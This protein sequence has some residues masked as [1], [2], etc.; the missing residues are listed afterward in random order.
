MNKL[1]LFILLV[2]ANL[3]AA[4]PSPATTPFIHEAFVQNYSE[5]IPLELIAATPPGARDEKPPLSKNPLL[6]WI[7]GYWAWNR[8]KKDFVW[9]CGTWRLPPPDRVWLKGYWTEVDNGWVWVRGAW[10]PDQAKTQTNWVYSK[11]LPPSAQNEDTGQNP[12]ADSFWANGYW[13]FSTATG[14]Y[15][16]LSGSWQKFNP[17]WVYENAHW[18][19]RP[20]G[21]LFVP[22]FWDWNLEFRGIAYDCNNAL[23]IG[24]SEIV[25]ACTPSYPDYITLCNHSWHFHPQYWE[26]CGCVPVWWSWND[27]WSCPWQSHWWL[28]WWYSHPGYPYPPFIDAAVIN[29]IPPPPSTLIN[30][31]GGF[32]PPIYILP[33]GVPTSDQWLDAIEKALGGNSRGPFVSA[34]SINDI[35]DV[36]NGILPKT[37]N[38]RPSGKPGQR[39]PSKPVQ[40]L[41]SPSAGAAKVPSFPSVTLPRKPLESPPPVQNSVIKPA[42]IPAPPVQTQEN[43]IVPSYPRPV[44][45]DDDD[46]YDDD[47]EVYTS[48]QY[49]YQSTPVYENQTYYPG[50]GGYWGGGRGWGGGYWGGRGGW[51]GGYWNGGHGGGHHGGGHHGGGGWN[52]GGHHGGG[53]HG[54]WNGG[55]GH[56]GGGNWGGGGHHGG[57]G[58]GGHHGG[59]GG[60]GHHGGGGGG[61]HG[62]GG[63]HHR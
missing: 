34:S 28:W 6:K 53:H 19:L 24:P 35:A 11:T 49:Y 40:P 10:M 38:E 48:P 8:D 52:G 16:W 59:G 13:N 29:A 61:H 45:Q 42:P 62:G 5:A 3:Y 20:E 56:H 33:A 12:G 1:L 25:K 54:G 26:G 37:G 63:G 39:A 27:W 17:E 50:Y 22:A 23:P 15:E 30:I 44:D 58:G 46:D 4:D 47:T 31:F 9:I 32:S 51:G 43:I 36:L 14:Q 60:G 21:Y 55:G 18:I 57:G 2:S 41:Q 7:P